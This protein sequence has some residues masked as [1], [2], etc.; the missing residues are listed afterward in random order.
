MALSGCATDEFAQS[1]NAALTRMCVPWVTFTERATAAMFFPG[2]SV[3]FPSLYEG[4]LTL[5]ETMAK[6]LPLC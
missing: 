6:R 5:L 1:W 3:C 4:L 2:P